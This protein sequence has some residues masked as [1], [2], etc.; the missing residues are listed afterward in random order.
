MPHNG[1]VFCWFSLLSARTSHRCI[2][3]THSVR[4][5]MGYDAARISPHTAALQHQEYIKQKQMRSRFGFYRFLSFAWFA[6]F[7]GSFMQEI[8]CTRIETY[9]N[10]VYSHSSQV[11]SLWYSC[12]MWLGCRHGPT[13]RSPVRPLNVRRFL[14]I[15]CFV[16]VFILRSHFVKT[17]NHFDSPSFALRINSNYRAVTWRQMHSLEAH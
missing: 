3:S 4:M 5:R 10:S 17:I 6:R 13:Q 2:E 14:G 8:T 1:K 9:E 15:S 7:I 12:C 11:S 16:F